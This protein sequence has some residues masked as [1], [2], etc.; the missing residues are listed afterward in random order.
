LKKPLVV[1]VFRWFSIVQHLVKNTPLFWVAVKVN[2]F[3]WTT[4][5]RVKK[6]LKQYLRS[7]PALF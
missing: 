1:K 6:V 5:K 4:K 2:G 7:F 3:F